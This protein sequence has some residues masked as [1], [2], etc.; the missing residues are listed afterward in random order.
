MPK[1]I[2]CEYSKEE[3]EKLYRNMT[4]KQLCQIVG[5]KSPITM[6][7][8]LRDLGISTNKNAM[9]A[10]NKRGG[11]TDQEFKEFLEKEYVIKKRSMSDIAK[12][13][14]ISRVIVSRYLDKYH[15]SKRSRSEQQS[16]PGAVNWKGGRRKSSN[17]YIE[18]YSPDHPN[19]NRRK[20]VYEHVLVMENKLG[21]YIKKG[22]F[23][24]HID[25]NKT[26]NNPDNLIVLTNE[27]HARVHN[28]IKNGVNK[29]EAIKPYIK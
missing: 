28:K 6:S 16:G 5:C 20:C 3:L 2:I 7:K 24:H 19:A 25:L 26:N 29:Y 12:E 4:L 21:R 27:E 17:G 9:T 8:K 10:E 11:R 1:K 13:L 14:N 23:I 15:I 22:E 18:I